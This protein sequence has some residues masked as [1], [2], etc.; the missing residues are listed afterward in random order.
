M[1]TPHSLTVCVVVPTYNEVE[2]IDPLL[3]V[4]NDVRVRIAPHV[5]KVLIVDDN[6]PDGTAQRVQEL[7]QEYNTKIIGYNFVNI[8][9]RPGKQG[10]GEAYKAGF[11]HAL[12]TLQGDIICEMDAD[13]SHN[14]YDLPRLI[15]RIEE[16]N[17]L[18]IGSRYIEGGEIPGN[19]GAHRRFMS[20]SANLYAKFLLSLPPKD[21]TGGFRAIRATALREIDFANL[22]TKGYAFQISLLYALYS[23]GARI[24]EVP[25]QF[26]DRSQGESK[27]GISDIM[28][29]GYSVPLLR[30]RGEDLAHG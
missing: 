21:C 29:L 16:G 1:K 20:K 10:L 13:F 14:P 2:N 22:I 24:S 17:D 11:T 23:H 9:Q 26:N 5:L 12:D 19:W 7:Q 25:I 6:S 4:L 18:V 3:Y 8:L 30:L 15:S 28:E 27:L